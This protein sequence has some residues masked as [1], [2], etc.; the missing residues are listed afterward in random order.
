MEWT[1]RRAPQ[2]RARR[3]RPDTHARPRV[4]GGRRRPWPIQG[5]ARTS[6]FGKAYLSGTKGEHQSK[7]TGSGTESASQRPVPA[8]QWR[9][10]C[11]AW[12]CRAAA[13]GREGLKLPHAP[14]ERAQRYRRG[15]GEAVDGPPLCPVG[16]RG[17]EKTKT[18]KTWYDT[19][20]HT[21]T[22]E[23]GDDSY[24]SKGILDIPQSS[25]ARRNYGRLR[26]RPR[27][28]SVALEGRSDSWRP[29]FVL[30]RPGRGPGGARRRR[31]CPRST[32]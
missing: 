8:T 20:T 10:V 16:Q 28:Q 30:R 27:K 19:E 1:R 13:G 5:P 31:T 26:T 25:S 24:V 29:P 21:H 23:W 6:K 4:L 2:T 3:R 15:S 22:V 32:F 14:L 12:T 11:S 9:P 18:Y 17:R 7:T